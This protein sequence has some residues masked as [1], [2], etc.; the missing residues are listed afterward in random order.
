LVRPFG[1]GCDTE[2]KFHEAR[3]KY[4]LGGDKGYSIT[5]ELETL[6]EKRSG[7][8]ISVHVDLLR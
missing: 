5:L 8:H 2:R 4:P 3:F 1:S 7:Q 6:L